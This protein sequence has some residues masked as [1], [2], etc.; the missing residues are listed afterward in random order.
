MQSNPLKR[1]DLFTFLGGIF[2]G[3]LFCVVQ[4]FIYQILLHVAD[5]AAYRRSIEELY[6]L[7]S[8]LNTKIKNTI[9]GILVWVFGNLSEH[10]FQRIFFG[11]RFWCYSQEISISLHHNCHHEW[12]YAKINLKVFYPAPYER[13][14]S[15]STCKC[16]SNP[17]SNWGIFLGKIF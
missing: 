15:L 3:K 11:K 4:Y 8:H 7:L 17:T 2:N 16:W 1:A 13:D 10:L 14:M 12:I 5:A 6:S 9:P